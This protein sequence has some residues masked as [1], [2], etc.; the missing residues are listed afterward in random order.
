MEGE[1]ICPLLVQ[2]RSL[3]ICWP[4]K[5][6]SVAIARCPS[7]PW[8]STLRAQ[9]FCE[10]PLADHLQALA[11]HAAPF[12]RT[13][14][15]FGWPLRPQPIETSHSWSIAHFEFVFVSFSLPALRHTHP[16]S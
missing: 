6:L 15:D 5:S 9:H 2:Y 8:R 1:M 11:G 3:G 13:A 16:S 4:V 10:V 12:W 7:T 14:S